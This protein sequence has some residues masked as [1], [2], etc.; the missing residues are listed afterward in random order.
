MDLGDTLRSP[1]YWKLLALA[2]LLGLPISIIALL[3]MNLVDWLM[4]LVWWELP[5]ALG[6]SQPPVWMLLAFPVLAGFGVALARKLP[7]DGGHNPLAG[8]GTGGPTPPKAVAGILI[9][10]LITLSL[11]IM[12]GPE[13][14]LVAMGSGVAG[15]AGQRLAKGS[16]TGPMLIAMSGSFAAISTLFG[17]PLA[18]AVLL[19]EALALGGPMLTALLLPGLM[20]SGVGALVVIGIGRYVPGNPHTLGLSSVPAG[21]SMTWLDLLM[22]VVIGVTAGVL[23][24]VIRRIGIATFDLTRRVG[25]IFVS[26]P[27]AGL[28]IALVIVSYSLVTGND[29]RD[30]M[31]SGQ[32]G[33]VPLTDGAI[34]TGAGALIVLILFKSLGYAFSLGSGFRGGGIFP[35]I[36]IGA[37][38]GLLA[39]ALVP[40]ATPIAMYAAGIGSV[41]AAALRL[42]LAAIVLVTLLLGTSGA[43]SV[44]VLILAVVIAVLVRAYTDKWEKPLPAEAAEPAEPAAAAA[45]R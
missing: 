12:L 33:I 15:F 18:A 23:V 7:G 19:I 43:S 5:T 20:A 17:S 30:V 45:L 9:A 2:G 40:S 11:G 36:F 27:L 41:V 10:A 31:F 44:P 42:P 39:S 34:V 22:G 21:G 37:G 4:Q 24:A 25:N 1:G 16:P 29:P 6:E 14:P 38:L 28:A 8:F 26:L 32:T 35:T 13:A 3:Y